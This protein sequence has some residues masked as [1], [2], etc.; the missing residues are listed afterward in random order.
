MLYLKVILSSMIFYINLDTVIFFFKFNESF[1][2]M[3]YTIFIYDI[4]ILY[5][6]NISIFFCR[7]YSSTFE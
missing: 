7:Y 5:V 6:L 1:V 2:M 3:I 4:V